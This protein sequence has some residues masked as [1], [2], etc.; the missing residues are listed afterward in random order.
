LTRSTASGRYRARADLLAGRRRPVLLR[1]QGGPVCR[2]GHHR[3]LQRRQAAPGRLSQ[4]GPPVLR[5]A[6]YE[7]GKA[8]ARASAPDHAYYAQ[9]KDRK[10]GKRAALSEARKIIRRA[11]HILNDLGDD[12]FAPA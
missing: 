12:A 9:V 3:L 2:P 4:Q 10:N 5:W 7:A 6:V 8:H 11:R 1:P